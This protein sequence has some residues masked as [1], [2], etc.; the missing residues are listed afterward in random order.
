[1]EEKESI[2][3]N[4]MEAVSEASGDK[5]SAEDET[6]LKKSEESQESDNKDTDTNNSDVGKATDSNGDSVNDPM[7]DKD[8]DSG[9]Q[10]HV[11][12]E[13]ES[14][15]DKD[16]VT[17]AESADDPVAGAIDDE[18]AKENDI[19][20]EDAE[21]VD[22]LPQKVEIPEES[23][24]Q[25]SA[26]QDSAHESVQETSSELPEASQD[27]EAA[28]VTA[29][30]VDDQETTPVEKKDDDVGKPEFETAPNVQDEPQE[31]HTQAL[32][33]FDALL[34]DKSDSITET[35]TAKPSGDVNL[36]DDDDDHNADS[37]AAHDDDHTG[38]G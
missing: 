1:M 14:V 32:D 21:T 6:H 19:K 36:D 20:L 31:D 23:N 4:S 38:V 2:P 18:T 17:N 3:E 12:H 34:K 28:A 5:I 22:D 8:G 25:E 13:N 30:E 33:P 35:S 10:N 9:L 26:S 29:S 7:S 16:K 15:S 37:V 11:E 27:S 24:S